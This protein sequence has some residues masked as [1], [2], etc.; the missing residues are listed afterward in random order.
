MKLT[1]M[2]FLVGPDSFRGS[3]GF[4]NEE[5]RKKKQNKDIK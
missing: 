5:E 2:S 4:Y 1:E 3:S